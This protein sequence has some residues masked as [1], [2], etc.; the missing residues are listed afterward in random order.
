[1]FVTTSCPFPCP[2]AVIQI[3]AGWRWR[4]SAFNGEPA[5]GVGT[6]WRSLMP[7]LMRWTRGR[8]RSACGAGRG[9]DLVLG[10]NE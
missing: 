6:A 10:G 4:P 7:I 5:C 3:R 2:I 1:M 8:G 9:D